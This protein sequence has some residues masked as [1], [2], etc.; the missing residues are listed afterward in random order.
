MWLLPLISAIFFSPISAWS[1]PLSDSFACLFSL[2]PTPFSLITYHS[3]FLV[4][5]LDFWTL[6]SLPTVCMYSSEARICIAGRR[7][8]SDFSSLCCSTFVVDSIHTV[9]SV[10]RFRPHQLNSESRTPGSLRNALHILLHKVKC[11]GIMG[12]TKD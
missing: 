11:F 12:S 2:C 5:F 10:L 4:S 6:L 8:L 7:G 3:P 9:Q 1:L